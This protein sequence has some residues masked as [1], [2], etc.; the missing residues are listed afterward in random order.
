MSNTAK[1]TRKNLNQTLHIHPTHLEKERQWYV[2]DA[3]GKTLGRLAVE[4]AK[5]IQ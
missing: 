4:V 2:V 5:K 1:L 3:S